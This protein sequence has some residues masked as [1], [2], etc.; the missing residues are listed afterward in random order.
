MD[1]NADY[2]FSTVQTISRD[3]HLQKFSKNHLT[4][5]LLTKH[6]EQELKAMKKY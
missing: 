5:L 1:S 2:L 4:T 3:K 6:I